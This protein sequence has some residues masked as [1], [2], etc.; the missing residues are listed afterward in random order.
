MLIRRGCSSCLSFDLFG[1]S[2]CDVR[3][4]NM[5]A[6]AGRGL[7]GSPEPAR[8]SLA[9]SERV[10]LNQNISPTTQLKRDIHVHPHSHQCVHPHSHQWCFNCDTSL[11]VVKGATATASNVTGVLALGQIARSPAP[12]PSC[13]LPVTVWKIISVRAWESSS[14]QGT[15]SQDQ[16]V[17]GFFD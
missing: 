6:V 17:V 9:S 8:A 15:A 14:G 1:F 3:L 4:F 5:L 16:P 10:L 7:S 13:R 12:C 11:A 2:L